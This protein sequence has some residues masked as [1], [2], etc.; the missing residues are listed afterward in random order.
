MLPKNPTALKM[1]RAGPTP[2]S[3]GGSQQMSGIDIGAV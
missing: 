2:T 1:M 3:A